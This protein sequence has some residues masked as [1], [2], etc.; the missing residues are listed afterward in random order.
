M[1]KTFSKSSIRAV[2]ESETFDLAG[3]DV[4]LCVLWALVNRESSVYSNEYLQFACRHLVKI[5][6]F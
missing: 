3:Q 1:S 2:S 5:F 4:S 6:H